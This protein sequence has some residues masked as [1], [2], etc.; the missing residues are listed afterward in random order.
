MRD[1]LICFE[2]TATGISYKLKGKTAATHAGHSP[3]EDRNNDP[4]P[5]QDIVHQY[6]PRQTASLTTVKN[7]L[8]T[9]RNLEGSAVMASKEV[10]VVAGS[11]GWC[12]ETT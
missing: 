5:T 2:S 3:D 9:G 6:P 8:A 7:V 12:Q 4:E 1:L 11:K 10:V